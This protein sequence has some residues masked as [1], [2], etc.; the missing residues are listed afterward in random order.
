[1]NER[2][3]E[4]FRH[5]FVRWLGHPRL[6]LALGLLALVL[7]S[8]SLAVGFHHS[9][10]TATPGYPLR[11]GQVIELEGLRIR[12]TALTGDGRAERATFTFDQD[13]DAERFVWLAREGDRYVSFRLPRS[14]EAVRLSPTRVPFGL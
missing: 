13:L 14:G 5:R 10:S 9:S 7:T 3:A 12:V 1:M 11:P 8:P 6:P 2:P 4:G